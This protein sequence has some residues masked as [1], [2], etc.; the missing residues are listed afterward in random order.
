M[1]ML[2]MRKNDPKLPKAT[3]MPPPPPRGPSTNHETYSEEA[4][5]AAQRHLD[6]VAEIAR[7][8]DEV[9][10]WRRRA[11]MAEA[12]I[13]RLEVSAQ[14][15]RTAIQQEVANMADQ[16]DSAVAKLTNEVDA[17]KTEL[18]HVES[19]L[20]I[21]SKIFLQA[22]DYKRSKQPETEASK[23][24]LAA[25]ADELDKPIEP[26]LP[27]VVAAGPASEEEVR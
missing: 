21:G 14:S 11:L 6:Q 12:E 25:I 3:N 27:R 26:P 8:A 19:H 23:L 17:L 9:E 7:L 24:G 18:N 4:M 1:T 15:E 16:R 22:L 20:I 13:K 10:E 5:R 2:N